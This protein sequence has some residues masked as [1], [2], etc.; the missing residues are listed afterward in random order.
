M[1][2]LF[3]LPALVC[4]YHAVVWYVRQR[5]LDPASIVIRYSPPDELSP[6]AARYLETGSVDWKSIAAS[7]LVLSGAGCLRILRLAPTCEVQ[8]LHPE[9]SRV[10]PLRPEEAL[11][12]NRLFPMHNDKC[13][14]DPNSSSDI[15]LEMFLSFKMQLARFGYRYNWNALAAVWL[16]TAL[17]YT[18]LTPATTALP[19][20]VLLYFVLLGVLCPVFWN[21][22]S[23]MSDVIARRYSGPTVMK[24]LV[25]SG[26][27]FGFFP[28][29][30]YLLCSEFSA[31]FNLSVF[32]SSIALLAGARLFRAPSS[33]L[34]ER[35]NQIEGYRRFL[36][37]VEQDRMQRL[38]SEQKSA[39][40]ESM[41][42]YAVALDVKEPVGD[43]LSEAVLF[44]ESGI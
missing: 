31:G 35:L 1:E 17:S 42:A 37:T 29:L 2:I 27:M 12:F 40:I 28:V 41:F 34:Q 32:T 8:N 30:I 3:L 6:A 13:L 36:L 25:M 43:H 18:W 44:V 39:D 38:S 15:A 16:A 23:V 9:A 24:V 4:A 22:F 11:V 33:A 10:V 5:A 21:W 7:V 26:I 20:I 14:L 19:T